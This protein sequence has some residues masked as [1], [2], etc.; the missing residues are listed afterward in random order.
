MGH[1]HIQVGA[2]SS[3][4]RMATSPMPNTGSIAMPHQSATPFYRL[5]DTTLYTTMPAT[6]TPIILWRI[7]KGSVGTP[8][9]SD[10]P[11]LPTCPWKS[12]P[13]VAL[14]YSIR[15]IDVSESPLRQEAMT[16]QCAQQGGWWEFFAY[17]SFVVIRRNSK[18]KQL[19]AQLPPIPI[20]HSSR[21]NQDL[22][23][24]RKSENDLHIF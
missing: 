19:H 8:R 4:T 20:H 16:L 1:N 13:L 17:Q 5:L 24:Y 14:K 22:T 12:Y 10:A 2:L 18:T 23:V 3:S 11:Y 7:T 9:T 6:T 21:P 15:H